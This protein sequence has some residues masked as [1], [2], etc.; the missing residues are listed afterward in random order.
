MF[1]Q[2]QEQFGQ[3]NPT[4]RGVH[5]ENNQSGGND[6]QKVGKQPHPPPAGSLRMVKNLLGHEQPLFHRKRRAGKGQTHSAHTRRRHSTGARRFSRTK[7]DCPCFPLLMKHV[8]VPTVRELLPSSSRYFLVV[9]IA[10]L[11]LRL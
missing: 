2:W 1:L 9:T 11:L 6:S 10:G 4:H 3:P 5:K 8:I 7:A